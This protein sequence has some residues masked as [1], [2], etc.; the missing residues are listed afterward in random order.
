[1][2]DERGVPSDCSVRWC[3]G[4]ARGENDVAVVRVDRYS[5]SAGDAK[6]GAHG[7]QDSRMTLEKCEIVSRG[8]SSAFPG[9]SLC[10]YRM[11]VLSVVCV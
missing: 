4:S 8:R 3:C 2:R 1:M 6:H 9:Q 7:V 10:M 5:R 11:R